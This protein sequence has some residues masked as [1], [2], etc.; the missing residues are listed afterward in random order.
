MGLR[1]LTLGTS[2]PELFGMVFVMAS[3]KASVQLVVVTLIK[4]RSEGSEGGP[5]VA[6]GLPT[7]QGC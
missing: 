4:L 6:T 7:F 1:D 2:G 3:A 5:C